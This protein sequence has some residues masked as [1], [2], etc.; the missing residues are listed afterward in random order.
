[1]FK[2]NTLALLD[3]GCNLRNLELLTESAVSTTRQRRL[4]VDK[5]YMKRCLRIAEIYLNTQNT[6]KLDCNVS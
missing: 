1:M 6:S 5:A 4:Y 3:Y 2:L